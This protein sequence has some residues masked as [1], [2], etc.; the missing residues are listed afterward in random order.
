MTPEGSPAAPVRQVSRPIKWLSAA[1]MH[2]SVVAG[3]L[4][5]L[6]VVLSAFMRYMIG[7][8]FYFSDELVGLLTAAMFLLALP[9]GLVNNS[10]LRITLV[11]DRLPPFGRAIAEAV[12]KLILVAF[13]TVFMVQSYHFTIDSYN[14]GSRSEMAEILLY[15]W[16]ALMPAVFALMILIV[17]NSFLAILLGAVVRPDGNEG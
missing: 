3:M 16:M 15:P 11:V 6:F 7:A 14:F 17:A 12:A 8:P 4:L 13:A 10:H 2:A 9:N 1:G 5:T